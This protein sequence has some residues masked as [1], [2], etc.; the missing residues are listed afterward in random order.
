M[1]A[2][3]RVL[4]EF[5]IAPACTRQSVEGAHDG[6]GDEIDQFPRPARIAGHAHHV[7]DRVARDLALAVN[8]DGDG[9]DYRLWRSLRRSGIA[10][11]ASSMTISPSL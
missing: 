10:L 3:K 6:V 7:D 11:S 4:D 5:R 1:A 9:G 8:G 2:K